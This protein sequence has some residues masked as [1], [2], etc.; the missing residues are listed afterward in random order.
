MKTFALILIVSFLGSACATDNPFTVSKDTT[1]FKGVAD[2]SR[3]SPDNKIYLTE[4]SIRERNG[5]KVLGEI[6]VIT[7]GYGGSNKVYQDMVNK[8]LEVGA[9]AVVGVQI[10]RQPS[11]GAWA[12]P[13]GTGIAI[14]LDEN[15]K[16]DLTKLNGKWWQ[17]H[18][19]TKEKP[20]ENQQI[21]G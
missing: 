20:P 9:D 14:K 17:A 4:D 8:A 6:R 7:L 1:I 2:T 5:Y 19:V 13:Q 15:S 10:W 3:P 16:V 18:I 11:G 21:D 12:A